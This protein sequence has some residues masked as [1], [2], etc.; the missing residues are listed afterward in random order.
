MVYRDCPN[1]PRYT[2]KHTWIYK[3]SYSNDVFGKSLYEIRT[4]NGYQIA[5]YYAENNMRWDAAED[6][7]FLGKTKGG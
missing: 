6:L 1:I 2:N 5:E 3:F 4:N 7:R